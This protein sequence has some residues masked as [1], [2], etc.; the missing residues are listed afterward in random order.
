LHTLVSVPDGVLAR[1]VLELTA[2]EFSAV[3][4]VGVR[5]LLLAARAALPWLER[6]ESPRIVTL[7]SSGGAL[8]I[9][10]YHAVGIAK[11]AL[12]SAL[13]YLA[14]ELGEKRVLCNG[15]SFSIVDTDAALHVVGAEETRRT[16][17]HLA[18]RSMTRAP[19]EYG[20]VTR[21]VAFFLSP[22]CRNITAQVLTVDG[23]YT[24]SYF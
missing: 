15:V 4:D 11:A 3:M 23:G 1:P 10:H 21:A 16:R 8:A 18:K 19:V 12:E 13:R 17:A 2:R 9:P 6:S 22:F 7:L 5:S 24:Q 20:D 14:L